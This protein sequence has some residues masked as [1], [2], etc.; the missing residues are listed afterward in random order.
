MGLIP[1]PQHT[2]SGTCS[3]ACGS[4]SEPHCKHQLCTRG[5]SW[6]FLPANGFPCSF[7]SEGQI[8][9]VYC[10]PQGMLSTLGC[11]RDIVSTAEYDGLLPQDT[12]LAQKINVPDVFGATT[13]DTNGL[14]IVS[15]HEVSRVTTAAENVGTP[16]AGVLH[17]RTVCTHLHAAVCRKK[18]CLSVRV[19]KRQTK[20]ILTIIACALR[21]AAYMMVAA[22]YTALHDVTLPENKRSMHAST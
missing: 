17:E 20:V 16:Y 11:S 13:E 18:R 3:K 9:L 1:G 22:V 8:D 21:H 7:V 4:D 5:R 12:E 14:R 15:L 10:L 2:L 6:R 19:T